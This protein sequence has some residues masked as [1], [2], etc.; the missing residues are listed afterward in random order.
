MHSSIRF[1]SHT[2]HEAKENMIILLRKA[3]AAGLAEVLT[4]E[5]YEVLQ[6][7]VLQ[8][9]AYLAFPRPKQLIIVEI[10]PEKGDEH[11]LR[12]AVRKAAAARLPILRRFKIESICLHQQGAREFVA[13]Y[14]EGLGLANYQFLKYRSE[15][16][17]LRGSLKDLRIA[18]DLISAEDLAVLQNKWMPLVGCATWSMSR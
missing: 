8:E 4:P 15:A 6:E 11:I 5:E 12:E 9:A 7:A 13:A 16:D 14:A 2:A 3:E 1:V 10:L 18:A 17:K